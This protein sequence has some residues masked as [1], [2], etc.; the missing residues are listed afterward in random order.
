MTLG[1]NKIINFSS[2]NKSE[3]VFPLLKQKNNIA[4]LIFRLVSRFNITLFK[5]L[6]RI[7]NDIFRKSK[8]CVKMLFKFLNNL[9][10]VF[11]YCTQ[12]SASVIGKFRISEE[13]MLSGFYI[14]ATAT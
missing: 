7:N 4:K 12:A 9:R 1:I 13:E 5:K 3:N 14:M 2:F 10:S 11:T 8:V 6:V